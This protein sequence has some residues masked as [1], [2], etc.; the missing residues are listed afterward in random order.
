MN[1]RFLAAAVTVILFGASL[2]AAADVACSSSARTCGS[3]LVSGTTVVT[4]GTNKGICHIESGLLVCDGDVLIDN[5][6]TLSGAQAVTGAKT[7]GTAVDAASSIL[8]NAGQ[9]S[10]EGSTAD[11][12]ETVFDAADA[13]ADATWRLPAMAAGT[14]NFLALEGAQ[15]V[16]GA[17]TFTVGQVIDGTADENQL[18]IQGHSTQTSELFVLENSAGTD[19]FTVTAAGVARLLLT[20]G[21]GDGSAGTPSYGFTG[22][23]SGCGLYNS[24]TGTALSYGGVKALS[25]SSSAV[26]LHL[27]INVASGVVAISTTAPTIAS[28]LCTSPA[29]S[30][31][32]GTAAFAITVGTSCA[33]ISTGTLTMP[34]ATTGWH[35]RFNNVTT[36]ASFIVDQTGGSTTTVT[37]TNYS[38]TTGLATD[39]TASESIR[40]SCLGY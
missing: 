6:V 22:C 26:N 36:P 3:A 31:S 13:T 27:P 32:N 20:Y 34:A 9:F 33:G 40:A 11:G 12:F 38:R 1:S 23:G 18:R 21:A 7:F 19:A 28:G 37:F 5:V 8:V 39:F 4:G 16:T 2:P 35:C 10:F 15:S 14:Y 30:A 24:V 17:K 25:V 29:I